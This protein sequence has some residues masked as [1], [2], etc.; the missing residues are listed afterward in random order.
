MT[1]QM[2]GPYM[3]TTQYHR[4]QKLTKNKKILAAQAEHAAWLKKM[5][6]DDE[7]L[8]KK[9]P[10]D[11]KGR[12]KGINDIPNYRAT[13]PEVNLSNKVAEHGAAV[14][15]KEYSGERQLL[16]IA[17]MHKSNMVPVFVDKKQ[18]AIDIAQMRRN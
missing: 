9:L 16:G 6:V 1:M 7:S 12:R 8:K 15:P 17:T 10:H 2:V 5:G 11:H 3:T 13:K 4:K 14:E 18:D